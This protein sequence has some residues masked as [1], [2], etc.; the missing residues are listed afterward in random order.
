MK[1]IF[2]Y[3][4]MIHFFWF[5]LLGIQPVP[6]IYDGIFDEKIIQSLWNNQNWDTQEGYVIRLAEPISYVDF[7]YKVAKFV[8]KDH[9]QTV[10]HWMHGQKIEVNALQK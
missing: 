7:K 9:I 10:K 5:E 3:L 8:R 4:G 2:A 1:K 6:T